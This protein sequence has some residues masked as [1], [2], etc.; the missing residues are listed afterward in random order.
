MGLG[1]LWRE[2]KGLESLGVGHSWAAGV[3]AQ[4]P[5]MS[6]FGQLRN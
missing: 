4:I 5:S 3:A 6:A 2:A 1:D